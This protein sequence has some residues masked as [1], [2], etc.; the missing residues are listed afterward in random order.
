[1][2]LQAKCVYACVTSTSA[3]TR[4]HPH[5]CGHECK[6]LLSTCGLAGVQRRY[7]SGHGGVR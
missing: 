6:C 3:R 7:N 2:K 1:M 5:S 4:T